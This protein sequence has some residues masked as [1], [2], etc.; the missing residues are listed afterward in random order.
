MVTISEFFVSEGFNSKTSFRKPYHIFQNAFRRGRS[1]FGLAI[2]SL[3]WLSEKHSLGLQNYAVE[4]QP[5]V[6]ANLRIEWRK[7]QPFDDSKL[8]YLIGVRSRGSGWPLF[9]LLRR[10]IA[11]ERERKCGFIRHYLLVHRRVDIR[12]DW[13][14]KHAI[15]CWRCGIWRISGITFASSISM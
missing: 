13:G 5:S 8:K 15:S 1:T 6:L 4:L 9:H 7:H 14:I 3:W 12:G 11:S 2:Q 10:S